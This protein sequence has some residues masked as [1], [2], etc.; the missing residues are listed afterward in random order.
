MDQTVRAMPKAISRPAAVGAK[1]L[2]V[3]SL[4]AADS[5]RGPVAIYR[6]HLEDDAAQAAQKHIS[7]LTKTL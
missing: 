4:W 3:W 2:S 6:K 1:C 7:R 5:L